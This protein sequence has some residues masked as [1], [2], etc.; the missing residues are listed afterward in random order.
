MIASA[1]TIVTN[2]GVNQPLKAIGYVNQDTVIMLAE[3]SM[4]NLTVFLLPNAIGIVL[5]PAFLSPFV[6]PISLK[7]DVM[8]TIE[9]N[10]MAAY[11]TMIVDLAS[12]FVE[13]EEIVLAAP[14]VRQS[15]IAKAI[16]K[17]FNRNLSF[18]AIPGTEYINPMIINSVEI[19]MPTWLGVTK[20]SIKPITFV[21]SINI[22]ACFF[23]TSPVGI[24]LFFPFILSRFESTRSFRTY[25]PTIIKNELKGRTIAFTMK[26]TVC[27]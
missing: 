14:S 24:G 23:V 21:K 8:N 25:I 7:G 20:L 27:C 12:A 3:I 10:I 26:S 5:L 16:D 17:V 19:I 4:A 1:E 6:S 9:P 18:R 11:I 2:V 15:I 13:V 22:I